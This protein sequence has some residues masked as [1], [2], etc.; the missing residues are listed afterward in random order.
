M[1]GNILSNAQ[2]HEMVK[3]NQLVIHPYQQWRLK[4]AHYRLTPSFV[5]TAGEFS[6]GRARGR[7]TPPDL[8]SGPFHFPPREYRI[9]EVAETL[10]LPEGIVGSFVSASTLVEQGFALTAGKLD[11]DYGREGERVILG[12]TN[13]LDRTNLFDPTRGFAHIYFIDFRG[14]DRHPI[15][16]SPEQRHDFRDRISRGDDGPNYHRD[17]PDD[18]YA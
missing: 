8:R 5:A 4:L 2:I 18:E 13:L 11:A 14:A 10:I 1:Y 6:D 15:D 16:F 17:D 9:I 3:S 7:S 12:M